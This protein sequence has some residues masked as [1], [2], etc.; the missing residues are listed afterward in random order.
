MTTA[1]TTAGTRPNIGTLI[2]NALRS[3]SDAA[4]RMPMMFLS[5]CAGLLIVPAVMPHVVGLLP[6]SASGTPLMVLA[7]QLVR[8]VVLGLFLAPVAVAVHRFIIKGEMTQ[9]IA[10]PV[11]GRAMSFLGWL[12]LIDLVQVLTEVPTA[13]AA[14]NGILQV[15]V[16]LFSLFLWVAVIL[17]SVRLSLLFPAVAIDVPSQGLRA[18]AQAS[19]DQ[20]RG[21]FWYVFLTSVLA[22]LVVALPF[23]L[24]GGIV[25]AMTYTPHI[26]PDGKFDA[27]ATS[28]ALD[29]GPVM[30]V[31]AIEYVAV[32]AAGAAALSWLYRALVEK[33][34]LD[35]K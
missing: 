29:D 23:M 3:A 26:G 20:T 19:W 10:L 31:R 34:A 22:T 7:I 28:L 25:A 27:A 14:F 11:S 17:V 1:D 9:G 16:A 33:S 8:Y 21:N 4:G 24:L 30:V 5:A 2:G 15:A 35:S 12:V 18:R 13:V 6:E 32:A